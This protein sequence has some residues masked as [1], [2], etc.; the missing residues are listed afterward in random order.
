MPRGHVTQKND[1]D[2]WPLISQEGGFSMREWDEGSKGA[3]GGLVISLIIIG[4]FLSL[5]LASYYTPR[6]N[7]SRCTAGI[8]T[9]AGGHPLP[10][11][12]SDALLAGKAIENIANA[13]MLHGVRPDSTIAM[14]A[15]VVRLGEGRLGLE[16]QHGL[17]YP[18]LANL[19]ASTD[20]SVDNL[21]VDIAFIRKT[22]D[23]HMVNQKKFPWEQVTNAVNRHIVTPVDPRFGFPWW[24]YIIFWFFLSAGTFLGYTSFFDDMD[25]LNYWSTRKSVIC[26][27][28]ALPLTIV[29]LAIAG[30]IA[31]GERIRKQRKVIHP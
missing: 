26:F 31:L 24:A 15:N 9:A 6:H 3:L 4:V 16:M 5:W 25:R 21:A 2:H 1:L 27:V 20:I 13:A 18:A 8:I 28:L 17:R 14:I 7:A 23:D 10:H 11:Y 19:L 29:L 22:M 12:P 30:C